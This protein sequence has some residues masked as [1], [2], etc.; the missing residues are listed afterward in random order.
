MLQ[1]GNT[2]LQQYVNNSYS[3]DISPKTYIEINGNDYGLPYFVG[4]DTR[5]GTG[6]TTT[7]IYNSIK[8]S[9]TAR[10]GST[11]PQSTSVII[12]T[13]LNPT[14]TAEKLS[15]DG[16]DDSWFCDTASGIKNVK[17]NMFLKASIPAD[18]TNYVNSFNVV[19]SAIGINSSGIVVT[20]EVVT[21]TVFVDS[22]DWTPTTIAFSNPDDINLVDKVRLE[23]SVSLDNDKK[24]DLLI[25]QLIHAS[26]SPYE[27]FVSNRL[28]ASTVFKNNRPGEFLVDIPSGSRPSEV[29]NGQTIH[30]QCTGVHMPMKYALGTKYEKIQRSVTPY[31]GNPFVYYVSGTDTA[32][33]KVWAL[34][35]NPV[36]TN[37]IVIKFNAIACKPSAYSIELLTT[38]G[39]ES[40]SASSVDSNG[41]AVFYLRNNAWS[42]TAWTGTEIPIISQSGTN[43]GKITNIVSGT[44]RL[45]EKQILGIGI[46]V[47]TLSSTNSDFAGLP[48]RM[49]LIELSPRLEVDLS[50]LTISQS[51][52]KETDAQNEFLNIG[53]VSSNSLD[54]KL[55]NILITNVDNDSLTNDINDDIRPISN[56]S[57]TSPFNGILRRGAKIKTGFLI[58]ATTPVYVPSFTGYLDKWSES[59][60]DISLQAFDIV[61]YLQ[62]AKTPSLYLRGKNV[63]DCIVALLDSCGMSD[64]YFLDLYNLK[65]LS[66]K[67]FATIGLSAEER[68]PFFW[69][70]KNTSITETLNNLFKVYQIAMY[71]DEY[72][73]I[74]FASLYNYNVIYKSLTASPPTKT[75]D[76]FVQDADDLSKNIKSNLIS[77]SVEENEVAN[78]LVIKYQTP[79][80]SVS[81]PFSRKNKSEDE[82]KK[83]DSAKYFIKQTTNI[84]WELQDNNS[85]LPFIRLNGEGIT[86]ISQ[87]Y[88]PYKATEVTSILSTLPYSSH[89]LIDNEIIS[90]EGIE[91]IFKYKTSM[92]GDWKILKERID[93]PEELVSVQNELIRGGAV[94]IEVPEPSG[95]LLNVKR[96][97]FGTMP[98][99]HTPQTS[100]SNIKWSPKK[101]DISNSSYTNVTS[102]SS[103]IVKESGGIRVNVDDSDKLIYLM[104][105][106]TEDDS[107]IMRD[108]NRLSAQFEIKEIKNNKDG[109]FGV[110]V[111]TKIS[112]NKLIEGLLI[113]IGVE[114][115]KNKTNPVV[116]VEQIINNGTIKQLVSKDEFKYTN[117]LV[118]EQEN[119]E[120][121]IILNKERNKCRVLVGGTDI[122]KKQKEA[123][124]KKKEKLEKFFELSQPLSRN[125]NFGFIARGS[126]GSAILGQLLFGNSYRLAEMNDLNINNINDDY[127]NPAG[128]DADATFFIGNSNLLDNIVSYQL[129]S[130]NFD[131][132]K[133][134][135]AWFGS[136]VAR[137]IRIFE[138]DYEKFPTISVPE[139]E[140]L[141]YSYNIESFQSANIFSGGG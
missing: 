101:F 79:R 91:F 76:L 55:S 65:V 47:N 94:L 31:K 48:M 52:I 27:V 78:R 60:E 140:F 2:A 49:E 105:D 40:I 123:K 112:G 82:K 131:N 103:S 81:E 53:G 37:K 42:N 64:V 111:G 59:D 116:W 73:G 25:G 135:F 1:S 86:S 88:I 95:K 10:S 129:I 4:T 17:F 63:V 118:D 125:S 39:W 30:Q 22:I 84:A 69:T 13:A 75:P 41:I 23:I 70:D 36:R 62:S 61:K 127:Q 136:P 15:C 106:N 98:S 77:A 57:S 134:N 58:N 46:T 51:I 128:A 126:G 9:L 133:D 54:V 11:A 132:K 3:V 85:T 115:N 110:A 122:F 89:L 138:V 16:G 137:G 102:G 50:N 92:S 66:Q 5:P 108:K 99:K 120:V 28:P 34:Y 121:F 114:Q 93:S 35:K 90:Y 68:I 29:I 83:E 100:N 124:K 67:N 26:V 117:P 6:T 139:I 12:P 96:G 130:G 104:P 33:N 119:I 87:N 20:S 38:A 113:Y 7:Q 72:G 141:G 32:S 56:I 19:I 97:L 109:F 44:E 107:E 24:A 14:A 21:E 80:P 43:I 74:K 18:T 45:A 71:C 8:L